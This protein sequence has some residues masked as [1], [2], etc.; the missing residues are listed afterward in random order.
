MWGAEDAWIPPDRAHRL[1]ALLPASRLAI[2]PD[3][4]HLIQLD[5]PAALSAE[6]TRWTEDAR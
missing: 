3:A 5:A 1:H 2:V 6:L 4:G